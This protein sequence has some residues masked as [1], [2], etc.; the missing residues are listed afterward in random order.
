MGVP[1]KAVAWITAPHYLPLEER[2]SS[3]HKCLD[4][5]IHAWQGHAPD[6]ITPSASISH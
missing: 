6:A 2:A 3:K 5:V 4:G 1:Q